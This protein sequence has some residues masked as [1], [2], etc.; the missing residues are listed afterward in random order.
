MVALRGEEGGNDG[1]TRN[2]KVRVCGSREAQQGVN[3][4]SGTGGA[5][6]GRPVGA[7]AALAGHGE[8]VWV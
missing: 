4:R 6:T 8:C 3:G 5:L 7:G 1:A 2:G